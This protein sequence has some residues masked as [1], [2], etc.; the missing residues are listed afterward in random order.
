MVIKLVIELALEYFSPWASCLMLCTFILIQIQIGLYMTSLFL[1]PVSIFDWKSFSSLFHS[2]KSQT[3]YRTWAIAL[4][5]DLAV[6]GVLF[7]CACVCSIVTRVI[8]RHFSSIQSNVGRWKFF[9]LRTFRLFIIESSGEWM[10]LARFLMLTQNN[11]GVC[12]SP[13]Q[14]LPKN[15]RE[16]RWGKR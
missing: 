15:S 6:Y 10:F 8:S 12:V 11:I 2:I 3:M 16:F 13:I 1:Q 14:P 4:F 7:V 9:G 5:H